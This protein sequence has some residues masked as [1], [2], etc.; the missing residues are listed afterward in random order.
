MARWAVASSHPVVA[1]EP[2]LRTPPP[3][4]ASGPPRSTIR[5]IWRPV[6]SDDYYSAFTPQPGHGT[7]PGHG[8][9]PDDGT[10]PGDGM[11]QGMRLPLHE[12]PEPITSALIALRQGDRGALDA[13]FTAVY[14]ELHRMAHRQ[15]GGSDPRT[16]NTTAL[17]HELFLKFSASA[18]LDARDRGHFLAVCARAMRQI[19]V[20]A[21]RRAG[22]ARRR[23]VVM[24][25]EASGGRELATDLIALDAALSELQRLDP[26]LGTTVELRF[27]GGLSV[28]ETAEVMGLSA[29]TVKRD[30]R[31]ARAFL[32]RTLSQ[33]DPH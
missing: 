33:A 10:Q 8:M 26:R 7:Q 23:E 16:L 21:A 20:D 14:P 15:L 3:N 5:T 27:F 24:S 31:T 29:R 32:H 30:W 19:I 17:V 13:L 4:P 11:D 28:E 18:A 12:P 25:V 6:K 2:R 1:S 22:A 9:Q